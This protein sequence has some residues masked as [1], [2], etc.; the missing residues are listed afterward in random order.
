MCSNRDIDKRLSQTVDDVCAL[1][2]S[3]CLF[4]PLRSAKIL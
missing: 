2:I 4:G 1:D 3:D